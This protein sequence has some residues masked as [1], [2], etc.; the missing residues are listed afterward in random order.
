MESKHLRGQCEAILSDILTDEWENGSGRVK[1]MAIEIDPLSGGEP[2][3]L[4][5]QTLRLMEQGMV[6]LAEHGTLNDEAWGW[7]EMKRMLKE[8]NQMEL[9]W[10]MLEALKWDI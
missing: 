6:K 1:E 10:R 4:K 3:V 7:K 8:A 9:M 5:A 2:E